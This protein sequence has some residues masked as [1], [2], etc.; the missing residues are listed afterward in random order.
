MHGLRQVRVVPRLRSSVVGLGGREALL[1]QQPQPRI[2]L[3]LGVPRKH[4]QGLVASMLLR[5]YTT[6]T[7]QPNEK[8]NL[9]TDANANEPKKEDATANNE[10]TKHKNKPE[11]EQQHWIHRPTKDELLAAASGALERLKIRFKWT[12]IRQVRPFNMDDISAMFSWILVGNL[13]WILLGTTTFCSLVLFTMNTVSAQDYFA[14]K[15]GD[16]LTRETGITVVFENAIVP[17]WKDGVISLRNVFVSRRPGSSKVQYRVQKGSQAIAAAAAK[18][19]AAEPV[20]NEDDDGN[21]TQFDLTIDCISVTLSLRKWM[22]GKGIL[23]DVEVKGVRGLVDRRHVRWNPDDD[24]TKY[25]N[26]H[27]HGDFE[28]DSFKLEDAL[29]TLYQPGADKP[30]DVSIFNCD[31]PQLRKHWLFYD[32]LSANNMSGSYDNSLFTIHPRQ[33][34]TRP[35]DDNEPSPWKKIN[36]LR[37]DGVDIKHLNRGVDGPFGWIESGNVDLL[38]DVMLPEDAE[39][40]KF[41]EV[42]EDIVERWEANLS[43][44]DKNGREM[45]TK[46]EERAREKEAHKY[47]VIDL[48]VQLNNTRAAVPIFTSDLTYINNALIRPIVAYINSRD[49]YIPI[50]CRVVKRLTDF[51]G[52]WTIYD[53]ELMDDVSAEVYEAFAKNVADDEARALRMRKVGFWSVQFAAQLLL[54]SLGALA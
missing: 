21:Y 25:K 36:R 1:R 49:T 37:I 10:N 52:S 27:V 38:A 48:R 51:E 40:F 44:R 18:A 26:V 13:L 39:Q 43:R 34:T 4:K 22:D 33:L 17:H 11:E 50:N 5:Q 19:G 42:M 41:T 7:N 45:V 46:V 31:L 54:L 23:Q 15:V 8:T 35:F 32:I 2:M 47:I 53:S 24:P 16:L 14:R 12:M 28:I 20:I 6:N 9:T 3:N 30:F 29:F